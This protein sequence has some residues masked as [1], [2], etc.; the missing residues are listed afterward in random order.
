MTGEEL[1]KMLLRALTDKVLSLG[2]KNLYC[3][4]MCIAKD[5]DKISIEV[6]QFTQALSVGKDTVRKYARE[7]EN[8]G[9]IEISSDKKGSRFAPN[10]YTI[11]I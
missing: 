8:R 11:N 1:G 7:L 5:F 4:I 2:A 10:R 3:Y 6:Q 9:Y